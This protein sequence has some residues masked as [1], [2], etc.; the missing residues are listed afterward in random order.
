MIIIDS[1]AAIPALNLPTELATTNLELRLL[2]YWCG[3]K[4]FRH[5]HLEQKLPPE[6]YSPYILRHNQ[7]PTVVSGKI[8]SFHTR[9]DM[10]FSRLPREIQNK[11]WLNFGAYKHLSQV[12]GSHF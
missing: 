5:A 7:N 2:P 10:Y 6:D 12:S 11:M 1:S 9:S 8:V 4:H 3:V